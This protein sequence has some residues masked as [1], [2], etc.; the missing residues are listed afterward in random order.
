MFF[1]CYGDKRA[2][3]SFFTMSTQLPLLGA[4][5]IA[6]GIGAGN[7]NLPQAAGSR[8]LLSLSSTSRAAQASHAELLLKLEAQRRVR[9][10]DAPTDAEAVRLRLRALGHPVTLF[11]EGAADRR[12]RLQLLL[13][14]AEVAAA[15]AA[16]GLASVAAAAVEAAGGEAASAAALAALAAGG[17][18]AQAALASAAAPKQELFYTPGCEALAGARA[19][20]ATFSFARAAARLAGEA[21]A[22]AAAAAASAPTTAPSLPAPWRQTAAWWRWAAGGQWCASLTP[23]ARAAWRRSRATGTGWPAWPGTPPRA[24]GRR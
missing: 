15:V 9:T 1:L 5:A 20:M 7:I 19:A 4:S 6:A 22:G 16:E 2:F 8:E 18:R 13:A 14:E 12:L 23:P 11:G 24:L 10:V 21:A 3:F 17:A